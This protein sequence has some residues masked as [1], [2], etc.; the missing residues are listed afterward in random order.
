MDLSPVS[1]QLCTSFSP[2][3]APNGIVTF[4]FAF[5]C[6]ENHFALF[7]IRSQLFSLFELYFNWVL[8]L[9]FLLGEYG[10]GIFYWP[11]EESGHDS[12]GETDQ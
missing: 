3:F 9:Y 7:P 12:R 11:M 4:C 8:M 5:G 2:G 6:R 1:S 10:G